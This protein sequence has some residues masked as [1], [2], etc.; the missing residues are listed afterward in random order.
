MLGGHPGMEAGT[1]EPEEV[2]LVTR[3]LAEAEVFVDVGANI[4]LYTCLARRAGRHTIAIE[5]HSENLR[6]LF[7]NL[8][9]NRWSDVEVFPMAVSAAPGIKDLYGSGTG[10]S[11]VSQWAHNS[12]GDQR[13]VPVSTLDIVVGARFGDKKLLIKIDVEGAE[14]DV[15]DGAA[16]LLARRP[17]PTWLVEASFSEH[18][19]GYQSP[20]FE[21]VF[22][23]FR[24]HGYE[25]RPVGEDREVT[26]EDIARWLRNRRQ[27]F[28]GYNFVF[29]D[30][31]VRK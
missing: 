28:G 24:D 23:R 1:F 6:I 21:A 14:L 30:A 31:G 8:A 20:T 27:D 3:E 11:L 17:R 29:R 7:F 4:G 19:V 22:A 12:A 26:A 13:A 2:D 25:A 10:A 18:H 16:G 15:L 9:A 5:P